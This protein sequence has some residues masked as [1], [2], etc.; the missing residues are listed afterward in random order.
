V[1]SSCQYRSDAEGQPGDRSR[2]WPPG[3]GW[4]PGRSRSRASR[5]TTRGR[6]PPGRRRGS[7]RASAIPPTRPS[8]TLT[9]RQAPSAIASGVVGVVDRLVQA[10]RGPPA[11]GVPGVVPQPCRREGLLQQTSGPARRGRPAPR[12]AGIVGVVAGVRVDLERDIRAEDVRRRVTG[13]RRT[14][15]DLDLDPHVPLIEV[16][17]RPPRRAPAARCRPSGIPTLTPAGTRSRTHRGGSRGSGPPAAAGRRPRPARARPGPSRGRA[18]A[19]GRRAASVVEGPGRAEQRGDEVVAEHQGGPVGEL[20]VVDRRGGGGALAPADHRAVPLVGRHAHQQH[21]PFALPTEGGRERAEREPGR[22]SATSVTVG[23]SAGSAGS[24]APVVVGGWS[25]VTAGLTGVPAA[26]GPHRGGEHVPPVTGDAGPGRTAS[27]RLPSVARTAWVHASARS[28]SSGAELLDVGGD[29]HET[30]WRVVGCCTGAPSGRR[31]QRPRRR[32]LRRAATSGVA[33]RPRPPPGPVVPP[34]SQ[35]AVDPVGRE[36][37]VAGVRHRPV[38]V[39][40]VAAAT[41][42]EP[43]QV[44]HGVAPDQRVEGPAHRR[45]AVLQRPGPLVPLHGPADAVA[46]GPATHP[47]DVRVQVHRAG[48]R[49]A[50]EPGGGR[51]DH[52]PHPDAATSP[53]RGPG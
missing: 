46:L 43:G 48:R 49:V 21:V 45:D 22:T 15:A 52:R 3:P 28:G 50:A 30:A 24:A 10:D 4:R 31:E 8:L 39:D 53:S 20:L 23:G 37:V 5:R 26:P 14:R 36:R 38:Q 34:R 35:T 51:G 29:L 40:V 16:A 1:R 19:P 18:R 27:H 44:Q 41:G 12:H 6:R 11:R 33:T 17:R 47:R 42:A 32:P 2:R 7:A 13:R 25:A 9:M